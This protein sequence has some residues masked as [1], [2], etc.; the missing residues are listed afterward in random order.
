[1]PWKCP[2]CSSVI[3]HIEFE[4]MPRLGAVYRCHVCRIEL[5][6]DPATG[7][8]IPTPLDDSE[9]AKKRTAK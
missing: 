9:P 8:L 7:R 2:A 6:A 3:R 5:T 4:D 1:M